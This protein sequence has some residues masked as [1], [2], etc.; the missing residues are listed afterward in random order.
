MNKHI[1]QF[2]SANKTLSIVDGNSK[3]TIHTGWKQ[4][5]PQELKNHKGN[6]AWILGDQDLIIDVDVGSEKQGLE[7]LHL[8]EQDLGVSFDKTV[9]TPSGGYHIYLQVSD[10]IDTT[11]FPKTIPAYPGID[12]LRK[13]MYCLIPGSTLRT[14]DLKGGYS[15]CT[16]NDH[17]IQ[18]PAPE[19][20]ITL[21]SSIKRKKV[22]KKSS[23]HN[24]LSSSEVRELLR[25]ISDE[26]G[27]NYK[28]WIQIG[29]GLHHWNA[30]MG[31]LLWEEFSK[32]WSNYEE[33]KT[34]YFWD[35]FAD[36]EDGKNITL[37]TI[38]DMVKENKA[39][40]EKQSEIPDWCQEW[41]K[42]CSHNQ[43]FNTK[44]RQLLSL[45]DFNIANGRFVPEGR[46]GGKP[47]AVKYISD[48][49][50]MQLVST[51]LY[52]PYSN[53]PIVTV[54]GE[55]VAN[56]YNPQTAAKP[57]NHYTPDGKKAIKLVQAH[58]RNIF[59]A[60][61]RARTFEN[62]IAHQV[63][64]PGKLL[65]WA[66]LV[67]G[68]EGV[69][70]TFFCDLFKLMFGY[71]NVG[72]VGPTEVLSSYDGWAAGKMINVLEELRIHGANRYQVINK[73]KEYIGN[74]SFRITEKYVAGH[75][76]KNTANYI[77]FTNHKNCIPLHDKD[78]RWWVIFVNVNTIE[79][80]EERIGKHH[81][82]YFNDLFGAIKRHHKEILKFFADYEITEE[83]KK[84]DRAP[85]TGEKL[86]MIATEEESLD[87][88]AEI[89]AIID[90]QE[91][92]FI[93][94]DVISSSD[95]FET[96]ENNHPEFRGEF[97][98]NKRSAILNKLGFS[99][100]PGGYVYISGK[101]RMLWTTKA[102]LIGK[103]EATDILNQWNAS[104]AGS[105]KAKVVSIDSAKPKKAFRRIRKG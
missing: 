36:R 79:E 43:F 98:T 34:A 77:A 16:P 103:K 26:Q 84:T 81:T 25:D 52:L 40:Q 42:V 62:W 15:F 54:D 57:A 28:T 46:Q 6:W 61:D 66:P 102:G 56:S 71:K 72:V 31:L 33:D 17:F 105:H 104:F 76:I 93:H 99:K 73:M 30:S 18:N 67:Q 51:M 10:H 94:K 12:F 19:S 23:N 92:Q 63:Q 78:R 14:G 3:K 21:L 9:K 35:S 74:Q 24:K 27:G 65:S 95:L 32:T 39:K 58:I 80:F 82:E 11:Q 48:N 8:L 38:V 69:G 60:E 89:K 1:K 85:L 68:I 70:K 87:G 7:S 91:Y 13:K 45:N 59:G 100:V 4:A 97:K 22:A 29:M 50:Y 64:N 96:L 49:G 2:T 20:L 37:A 55:K 86:S 83:F 53:E 44:T 101:L 47:S 75:E 88:L 90:S 41:V 5:T